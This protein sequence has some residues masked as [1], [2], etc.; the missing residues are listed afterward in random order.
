MTPFTQGPD[1][2]APRNRPFADYIRAARRG[3]NSLWRAFF[4]VAVCFLATPPVFV[5]LTRDWALSVSPLEQI[6]AAILIVSLSAI[7]AI[8][9]ALAL[10]LPVM[11]RRSLASVLAPPDP[12]PSARLLPGLVAGGALIC[13]VLVVGLLPAL[14]DP[15][16]YALERNYLLDG[17]AAYAAVAVVAIVFQASAEELVFRGY[18]QQQLAARCRSPWVWAV[19]PSLIFG[20]LHFDPRAPIDQAAAYVFAASLFG[21]TAAYATWRTG[22]LG[23]AIGM[24]VAINLIAILGIN[25]YRDDLDA[26]AMYSMARPTVAETV[27]SEISL[28]LTIIAALEI[29]WSPVNRWL[30][31]P[32]WR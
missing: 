20:W 30:R 2:R 11:H 13:V 15:W 9:A 12:G 1:W 3:P 14:V 32:N 8:W 6:E 7:G 17:Y 29:P 28:S 19:L 18:L 4:V 16:R 27:A 21:L 25:A 24:H 10:L 23:L 5:L 22:G 26:V 31:L